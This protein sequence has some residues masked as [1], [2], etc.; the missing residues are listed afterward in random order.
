M[1]I[2]A[3]PVTDGEQTYVQSKYK[4]DDIFEQ[5]DLHIYSYIKLDKIA[6]VLKDH[7]HSLKLILHPFLHLGFK[8][9]SQ[10][11]LLENVDLIIVIYGFDNIQAGLLQNIL[12]IQICSKTT[13]KVHIIQN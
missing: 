1:P 10:L 2:V 5:T 4:E 11:V 7:F 8:R 3:Y 9:V 12:Y 13:L 6:F